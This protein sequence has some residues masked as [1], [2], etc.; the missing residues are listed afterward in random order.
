MTHRSIISSLRK[1]YHFKKKEKK[2]TDR[3]GRE[4]WSPSQAPI[5]FLFEWLPIK[6][7]SYGGL[8]TLR[9]SPSFLS[10][11]SS[12]MQHGSWSRYTRRPTIPLLRAFRRLFIVRSY[13][14]KFPGH[15]WYHD[16]W[17]KKCGCLQVVP[18]L[19]PFHPS[20]DEFFKVR[21]LSLPG[22]R[23]KIERTSFS[24]TCCKELK[25]EREWKW[26][27]FLLLEEG[28]RS[29]GGDLT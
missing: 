17:W 22:W 6:A 14:P 12:R 11:M 4:R 21:S 3:M 13:R 5:L 27:S 10:H 20:L 28:V 16:S 1:F 19:E 25:E 23:R 15:E 29:Y 9:T 7:R 26:K 18:P 2:E 24:R 8:E